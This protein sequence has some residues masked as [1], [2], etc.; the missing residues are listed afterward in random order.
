MKRMLIVALLVVASSFLFSSCY[1]HH[2]HISDDDR[3]YYPRHRDHKPD[4]TNRQ[5]M[6]GDH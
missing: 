2:K 6:R 4:H 3:G 5:N 1:I